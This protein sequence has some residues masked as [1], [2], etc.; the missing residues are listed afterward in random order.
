MLIVWGSF[1]K[2]DFLTLTDT[3]DGGNLE[4]CTYK[5]YQGTNMYVEDLG[6][7]VPPQILVPVPV[8]AKIWEVLHK[9]N[10][11]ISKISHSRGFE[12]YCGMA[13]FYLPE[14]FVGNQY[15]DVLRISVPSQTLVPFPVSAKI[16]EVLL[17]FNW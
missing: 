10:R 17:V 15:L 2:S 16:W 13:V 8:S 6:I 7:L 11:F 1:H 12:K 9:W 5:L 3:L 14:K 4:L